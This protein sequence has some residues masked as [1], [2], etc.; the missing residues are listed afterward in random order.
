MNIISL[1]ML[2]NIME[3]EYVKNVYFTPSAPAP[4]TGMDGISMVYRIY[5]KYHEVTEGTVI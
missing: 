5:V 1:E 4:G 3:N 2:I